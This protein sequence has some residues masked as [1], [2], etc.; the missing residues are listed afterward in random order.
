MAVSGGMC[1]QCLTK[2]ESN[3]STNMREAN[4]TGKQSIK[5]DDISKINSRRLI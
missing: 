4:S 1:C 2:T 3:R 5:Y